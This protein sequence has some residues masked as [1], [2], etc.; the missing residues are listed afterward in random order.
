MEFRSMCGFKPH[1][2]VRDAARH[3]HSHV[4]DGDGDDDYG[5]DYSYGITEKRQP[6]RHLSFKKFI[7]VT[8]HRRLHLAE[9]TGVLGP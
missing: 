3:A 8:I 6:L 2:Q 9:W 7:K 5:Y 1:Q 4:V